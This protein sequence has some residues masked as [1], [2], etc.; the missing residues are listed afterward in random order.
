MQELRLLELAAHKRVLFAGERIIDRYRH[1]RPLGRPTKDAIISVEQIELE[2]FEGGVAA[3]AK[4]AEGFAGRVDVIEGGRVFVKTRFVEPSHMRKLFQ[5]YEDHGETA[6][7]MPASLEGY[8]A[9][10][11]LDYGH[12]MFTPASIHQ[13]DSARFL[14]ANVQTNSGNYGYNLATKYA[15]VDYLCVDEDEAR[16]ATLNRD[17]PIEQSVMVLAARAAKVVVTLGRA[18]AIGW[19]AD[20]DIVYCPAFTDTVVDTLGAGD[21]FFALTALVAKEADMLS[22]LRIGNAAGAIKAGI[23]GHR[24]EVTKDAL[25]ALLQAIPRASSISD[26][27]DPMRQTSNV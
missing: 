4:H 5:Y 25:C 6:Y 1:V 16:L 17:G 8:Q 14:C 7:A 22:L 9:V 11:L 2:Q 12:G 21:A 3:A 26:I 20:S 13:W 10:I 19:S 18:G 24:K 15:R 27:P 23:V